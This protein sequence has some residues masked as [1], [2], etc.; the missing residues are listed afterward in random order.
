MLTKRVG[1]AVEFARLRGIVKIRNAQQTRC[2]KGQRAFSL[3]EA[4]MASGMAAIAFIA[5]YSSFGLAF[6]SVQACRQDLR[7]TQI[8][9]DKMEAFKNR[10]M[11]ELDDSGLA[12]RTMVMRF[13]PSET[14]QG[15]AYQGTITVENAP[16]T[17]AYSNDLRLVTVSLT[18]ATGSTT[19]RKSMQTLV[20]RYGLNNYDY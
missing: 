5:L 16:G 8:L 6:S 1:P 15:W 9:V 17:E 19:R 2:R 4:L 14:N 13:S 7:A 20:S 12:P 11:D 3:P 10:T 18:W